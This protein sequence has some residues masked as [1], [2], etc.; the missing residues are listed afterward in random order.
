[1]SS[2]LNDLRN[3]AHIALARY[4]L[5][6]S[7]ALSAQGSTTIEA[8]QNE[9]ASAYHVHHFDCPQCIAAGRGRV[10]SA[11]CETGQ[12][13]FTA[14]QN[15][16]ADLKGESEAEGAARGGSAATVAPQAHK[17]PPVGNTGGSFRSVQH[18]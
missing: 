1:M 6:A 18:G 7:P 14:C 13:L 11:R 17:L 12:R 9:L 5:A 4:G 16:P 8:Q 10:Y 3:S 2:P 15:W